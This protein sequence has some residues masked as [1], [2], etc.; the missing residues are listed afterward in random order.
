M[1][2]EQIKQWANNRIWEICLQKG[3][4]GLQNV[5]DLIMSPCPDGP[6]QY[7]IGLLNNKLVYLTV[8]WYLSKPIAAHIDMTIA[9]FRC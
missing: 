7:A 6:V 4:K 8:Q 1:T 5:D 3:Y 2:I 9:D